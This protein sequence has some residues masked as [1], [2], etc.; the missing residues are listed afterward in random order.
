MLSTPL[1]WNLVSKNYAA[2]SVD[3]FVLYAKDALGLVEFAS[4]HRVL[5]IA[6]GTGDRVQITGLTFKNHE[7]VVDINGGGKKK[8]SLRD[9]IQI[10]VGGLPSVS[11]APANGPEGFQ[12]LGSTIIVDFGRPL[13]DVSPD[14]LKKIL[15]TF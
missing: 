14:E 5:D 6:A 4:N 15:G 11:S 1:P 7:I 3:H 2:Q 12:G 13:P 10:S 9:R 8:R